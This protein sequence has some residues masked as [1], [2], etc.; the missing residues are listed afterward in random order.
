VDTEDDGKTNPYLFALVG[1][2]STWTCETREKFLEKLHELGHDAKQRN[3]VVEVWATNL[4]YDLI[5]LFGPDRIREVLIRFGKTALVGATW[6]GHNVE[7]RDTLR[8]IPASVEELGKLVGLHKV[9]LAM[10][11]EHMRARCIRDA[12]I[13]YRTARIVGRVY[14]TFKEYPRLTLPSTAYHIWQKHY[15]RREVF[16]PSDEIRLAARDAYHGGRTEAFSLGTYDRV[17]VIDVASMYPWALTAGGMGIPW[18]PFTRVSEGA[19]V[20]PLGL[21]RVRVTVPHGILPPLPFRTNDGTVYPQGTWEAWY[22]GEEL[23]YSQSI[24]VQVRVLEGFQ[25]LSTAEPFE[26]Y[27]AMLFKR[28]AS[29]RGAMRSVYKLMLNGIYGK[30]GQGGDRV[31]CIPAEQL[32]KM[33]E[34]PQDFRVWNGLVFYRRS[35]KPPPWGNNLWAAV[36]TA[37]ARVKLHREMS[38]LI[39]QGCRVLYC[40]T[41]S[42]VYIGDGPRYPEKAKRAGVFESRGEYGEMLIVG[43]KEYGLRDG[44]QWELHAKGVPKAERKRYLKEGIA[45][46]QRPVKMRESSRINV[47][48]NTWRTVRKERRTVNRGREIL[49]DGRL[50]VLEVREGKIHGKENG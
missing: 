22:M 38:R 27:V 9:N 19:A 48:A 29:A 32:F 43:K 31:I 37:R 47:A 20:D 8:H 7:F 44:R 18:G 36:T 46:F 3:R 1:K 4:E 30:F 10:R 15:F 45:E 16:L 12:A 25:F 28:K 5:N 35:A 2:G 39:A 49:P 50:R 6:R 23:E 14:A 42:V 40:D 34:P 33:E 24:G 13:T 21:Y 11:A 17:H 26:K 41:D